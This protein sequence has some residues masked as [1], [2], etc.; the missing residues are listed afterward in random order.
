LATAASA[1]A[2]AALAHFKR[3]EVTLRGQEVTVIIKFY[4]K[5]F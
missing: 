3:P 4:L 1:A 2:L 5:V